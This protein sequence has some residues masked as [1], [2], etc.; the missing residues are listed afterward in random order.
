L[1]GIW[2]EFLGHHLCKLSGKIVNGTFYSDFFLNLKKIMDQHENKNKIFFSSITN[3]W[4]KF[5]LWLQIFGNF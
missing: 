2:V 4:K 1:V 3:E 5:R